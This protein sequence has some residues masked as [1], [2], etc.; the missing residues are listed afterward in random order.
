[1]TGNRWI[2]TLRAV[3]IAHS[4]ALLA[5]PALAGEFLSGADGIVKFHEWTGWVIIALCAIQIG[6]VLLAM[7]S[8]SA[9]V[10]LLFG[11]VF[12]LLAEL[13]QVGSGYGRFLEVHVP[14]GVIAFGIVLVQTISVFR[15]GSNK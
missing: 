9:S 2:L 10:W 15:A 1:L 6:L 5:Q 4:C 14:L 11:S 12:V 7:R 8:A 13:L 3:L